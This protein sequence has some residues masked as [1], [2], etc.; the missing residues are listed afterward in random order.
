MKIVGINKLGARVRYQSSAE[1][2]ITNMKVDT[3]TI[4]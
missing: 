1:H 4:M 2:N 3:T